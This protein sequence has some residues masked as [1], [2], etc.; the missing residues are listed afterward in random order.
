MSDG[1]CFVKPQ[2]LHKE[3]GWIF[4]LAFLWQKIWRCGGS[5]PGPFTCKANALPLSYIPC[6]CGYEEEGQILERFIS[7]WLPLK[8]ECTHGGTRTP[9]LRFRRPTPYPLGHAGTVVQRSCHILRGLTRIPE[10]DKKVVRRPGI[11]P[12]S[13]E[14]ESCMIPLHQRR[15]QG[16]EELN[17]QIHMK[18]CFYT[19][20]ITFIHSLFLVYI[21]FFNCL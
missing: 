10:R 1:S 18:Y 9:N 7:T 17:Q 2:W 12:G 14:W 3:V 15:F 19:L 6:S 20:T 11:E 13:Q 16:I 4:H 5:N 21:I 8:R